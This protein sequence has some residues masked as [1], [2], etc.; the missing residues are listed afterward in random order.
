MP[1]CPN[2]QGEF[3]Q[4]FTHCHR[5]N[6]PLV[7]DLQPADP[8]SDPRAMAEML[9]GKELVAAFSGT[10]AGVSEL[11]DGLAAVSIPS[12]AAAQNDCTSG[13]QPRLVLLVAEEDLERAEEYFSS[14]FDSDLQTEFVQF[15]GPVPGVAEGEAPA[16]AE[17]PA[18]GASYRPGP[19]AECPECG[20][21]LGG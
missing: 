12:A 15:I 17:C 6:V 7:Q 21:F 8:F 10:P 9:R 4:G 16:Q 14:R 19:E 3:R 11:R 13:C 18:C 5:C 1:Y 20:L 2:C